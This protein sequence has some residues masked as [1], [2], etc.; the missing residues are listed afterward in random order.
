M[1]QASTLSETLPRRR[2]D[3]H[4]HLVGD[5]TTGDGC[6]I[7]VRGFAMRIQAR[8]LLGQA[9]LPMSVLKTGLDQPYRE[10][11]ADWIAASSLDG[12]VLLAMDWPHHEDGT[13][14]QHKAAFYIPNRAVLNMA[15]ARAPKAPHF[16]PAVSIHPARNDA[17]SELEK[18]HAAGARILKLLPNVHNVDCS[19]P[20]YKEFWQRMAELN[21]IFLSHTGGELALPVINAQF[22]EPYALRRPLEYGVTTIAAHCGT[23]DLPWQ[24]CG[25]PDWI[26]LCDEFPHLYGDNSALAT[27]NRAYALCK[28]LDSPHGDRIIH[29]S[30]F[31]IPCG[32]LGPWLNRLI[33]FE[34]FRSLRRIHNPFER[35]AEIKR[36]AGFSDD[37]FTRLDELIGRP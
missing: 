2:L 19:R 17:I 37:T 33:K 31:P 22:A 5:G 7:F 20:Q 3:A 29:G 4:V 16:I 6:R 26:K 35:D 8:V 1:E 12:A 32:P 25:V 28:I 23:R 21:M 10:R 9:G 11:L 36:R 30:D 13:P 24:R 14:L 18:C 15:T 34:D 27:P